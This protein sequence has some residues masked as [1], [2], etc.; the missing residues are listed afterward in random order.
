MKNLQ[1]EPKNLYIPLY[2]IKIYI[3]WRPLSKMIPIITRYIITHYNKEKLT[4]KTQLNKKIIV[5]FIYLEI[6]LL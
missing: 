2:L 5:L 6:N 4:L 1:I 3:L